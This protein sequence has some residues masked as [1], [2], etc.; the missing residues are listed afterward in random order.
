MDVD[1]PFSPEFDDRLRIRYK[2]LQQVRE[3]QDQVLQ[4]VSTAKSALEQQLAATR[5]ELEQLQS[6]HTAV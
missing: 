1:E 4:Q 2:E 5:R 6:Y 3:T